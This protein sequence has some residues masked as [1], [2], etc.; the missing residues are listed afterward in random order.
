MKKSRKIYVYYYNVE[1]KTEEKLHKTDLIRKV[2]SGSDQKSRWIIEHSRP[3]EKS[4][5]SGM[6][7]QLTV[8]SA[9]VSK[10]L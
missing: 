1:N 7:Q 4:V 5:I 10:M 3:G 6:K 8:R 9:A 2:F